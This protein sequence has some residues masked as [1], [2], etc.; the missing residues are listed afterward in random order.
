[1]ARTLP[2]ALLALTLPHV[3]RAQPAHDHADGEASRHLDYESLSEGGINAR[4]LFTGLSLTHRWDLGN[5]D[6]SLGVGGDFR[7]GVPYVRL[8]AVL[9]LRVPLLRFYAAYDLL[10][11]LAGFDQLA[12][13]EG[14]ATADFSDDGRAQ[15]QT[16]RTRGDQLRLGGRFRLDLGSLRLVADAEARRVRANVPEGDAL[17]YDID[18]DTLLDADGG[19]VTQATLEAAFVYDRRFVVGARY[20]WMRPFPA[21]DRLGPFDRV[22]LIVGLER[23]TSRTRRIL[24]PSVEVAAQWHLRHEHRV[25]ALPRIGITIGFHGDLFARPREVIPAGRY[26][27]TELDF[28]GVEDLD[29][30]TLRSCLATEERSRF[31]IN[32]GRTTNPSCGEPP[33]EARRRLRL[34]L[35]RWPWREWPVYDR[36]VF[37][38]DLLRVERWYRARGY[39]D[40]RVVSAE[41]DPPNAREDDRVEPGEEACTPAA[42]GEGCP[43]AIRIGVEEGD[44]VRV[45][46]TDLVIDDAVAPNV[47]E[48][49]EEAW[50]LETGDRFDEALYDETKA[51]MRRALQDATYACAEVEGEVLLDTDALTAAVA[52]TASPGPRCRLGDIRVTGNED[53]SSRVVRS[54]ANL[55]PDQPYD[56][57]ELTAAQRFIYALGA[58]AS[59]DVL[60]RPRRDESGACTGVVDV[61]IQVSP[62]RRVRY[63]LGGGVE[64]GSN[65]IQ[66]IPTEEPQGN[67][68]LLTFLEHRNFLG[69]LRR[70]R[71]ELRP[72]LLFTL[73]TF[74]NGTPGGDF[75]AELR[76][77]AFIEPRTT[78]VISLDDDLGPDPNLTDR[79]IFRNLF[80]LAPGVRR[81]FLD[82]RISGGLGVRF[83]FYK[84]FRL[85]DDEV[86]RDYRVFFLEQSLNFDFRDDS[87]N[88]TRWAFFG[89]EA[90]E[91]VG[92]S[93][94]YLR[95]VGDARFY[96][97]LGPL[98]LA[99]RFRVS[100]MFILRVRDG[101]LDPVSE[102]LG[103]SPFRLRSG[104]PSS[105][106]GFVAGFLGDRDPDGVF[107]E[108]SG[109]LRRWEGSVELRAPLTENLGI[110]TFADL[111][112]VN[113]E[114]ELRFDRIRLALGLGLRYRVP[115]IGN[116]RLDFGFLVP[117]AQIV[118]GDAPQPISNHRIGLLGTHGAVHVSIGEAF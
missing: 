85:P 26:G 47:G 41:F 2:L 50:R 1:M 18:A 22:G 108:N 78:G 27:V 104:G 114:P 96:F 48:T 72:K 83:N 100:A 53:L 86:R 65:Q 38:R 39:Y 37:E 101:S 4:H 62:G 93:W 87:R 113:R 95:F 43:V 15:A 79:I 8:G 71:V 46:T 81:T 31:T 56:A 52:I 30:E 33:F 19:W 105:H 24:G 88:P 69:G 51:R 63:G 45:T 118:G 91:A 117:S 64:L 110:V 12:T 21:R 5:H 32:L 66:G 6:T 106:R 23:A 84:N 111:G 17:F 42:E 61:I 77:P 73:P 82:G 74:T 59:V 16:G 107:E 54:V 75:R 76:Q 112:D 80:D 44:P 58:F 102:A 49:L 92:L 7:L 89:F 99:A 11:H 40:A 109:G 28:E 55:E 14:A 36:N 115:A 3:A 97:P 103:P 34:D 68:H 57:D 10:G 35:W 70:A 116:V 94:D 20:D 67:V 98:V 90:H 25:G 29:P 60:P 13:Y 9:E